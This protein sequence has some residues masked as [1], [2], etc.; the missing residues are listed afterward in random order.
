MPKITPEEIQKE[1]TT[2]KLTPKKQAVWET[3]LKGVKSISY[4]LTLCEDKMKGKEYFVFSPTFSAP[5]PISYL[6]P[7]Q[8]NNYECREVEV[9][10]PKMTEQELLQQGANNQLDIE[11]DVK[12]SVEKDIEENIEEDVKESVEEDKED[13][14]SD[15]ERLSIVEDRPVEDAAKNNG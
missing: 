13:S 9:R 7:P 6:T 3:N 5:T 2:F 15:P 10:L 1:I 4:Q 11:E 12:E 8:N 14:D